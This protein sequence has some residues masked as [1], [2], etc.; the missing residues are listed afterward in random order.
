MRSPVAW[1]CYAAS[2][3]HLTQW[4]LLPS[5]QLACDAYLDV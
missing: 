4:E 1:H 3:L 2:R 5:L